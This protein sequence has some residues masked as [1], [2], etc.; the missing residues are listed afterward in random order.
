LKTNLRG[1]KGGS[2]VVGP[3]RHFALLRHKSH[4][5]I[6]WKY[7]HGASQS[8]QSMGTILEIAFACNVW[9]LSWMLLLKD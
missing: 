8:G 4:I 1:A 2:F 3:G 9:F 7:W 6:T 5:Q